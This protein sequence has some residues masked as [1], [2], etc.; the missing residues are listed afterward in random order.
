MSWVLYKRTGDRD[1][2]YGSPVLAFNKQD[3]DR[4]WLFSN[5]QISVS[6]PQQGLDVFYCNQ[7]FF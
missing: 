7:C 1:I 3:D 6:T 4:N 5:L 2:F